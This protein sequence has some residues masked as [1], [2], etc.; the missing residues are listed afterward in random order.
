MIS[1]LQDQEVLGKINLNPKAI[2][3]KGSCFNPNSHRSNAWMYWRLSCSNQSV[4]I[5]TLS[6]ENT[7]LLLFRIAAIVYPKAINPP[8]RRTLTSKVIL[9]DMMNGLSVTHS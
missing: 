5:D 1:K 9:G 4:L 6:S 7:W 2:K 3:D 8:S